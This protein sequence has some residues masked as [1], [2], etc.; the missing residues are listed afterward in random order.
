MLGPLKEAAKEKV[1]EKI[2][3]VVDQEGFL[4]RKWKKFWDSRRFL[5]PRVK[6]CPERGEETSLLR[7][8]NEWVT[9]E[10]AGLFKVPISLLDSFN[11]DFSDADWKGAVSKYRKSHFFTL[12]SFL[13]R[14]RNTE[15]LEA[16]LTLFEEGRLGGKLRA[17][18]GDATHRWA[19][20]VWNNMYDGYPVPDVPVKITVVKLK[21]EVKKITE[22]Y[23]VIYGRQEAISHISNF[24]K[25]ENIPFKRIEIETKDFSYCLVERCC[26]EQLLN[27]ILLDL[28]DFVREVSGELS[29]LFWKQEVLEE[30][31]KL[32]RKQLVPI[33]EKGWA[34][35]F[36]LV[37]A[38][39]RLGRELSEYFKTEWKEF[40]PHGVFY[41]VE[42]D[43]PCDAVLYLK[44]VPLLVLF[45]E[46][47]VNQQKLQKA[48]TLF[49]KAEVL[50]IFYYYG[51]EKGRVVSLEPLELP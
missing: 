40:A 19:A 10:D 23:Y 29:S 51:V 5:V 37:V 8:P 43:I 1:R 45:R 33:E 31:W 38:E 21:D 9:T 11:F 22:N 15:L 3:E 41:K 46:K 27:L 28:K 20:L 47:S 49:P 13:F 17:F 36:S 39:D 18:F 4:L 12:R 14:I 26:S 7:V 35:E 50:G 48:K 24:L 30:R 6:T 44:G 16:T 25:I 2:M 34:Q 42:P 32:S